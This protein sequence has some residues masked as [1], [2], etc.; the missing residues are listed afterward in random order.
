MAESI[1]AF[2]KRDGD[3][4]LFNGDG[5]FIFYVP[6]MYFTRNCAVTIGDM[7]NIIGILDYTIV[8]KNGKNNG[9]HLFRFPTVFLT[10]P[11][12]IEKLKEV[13]L[14]KYT[15]STDYRLLKYKKGDEI[16][17]SVKVPQ[18]VDNTEQFYQMFTSGKLPTTIPYDKLHEYFPENMRLNGGDYGLNLQL[19]GIM[20]SE[21]CRD[22]K[23]VSRLFR[24]TDMKDMT[25][26]SPISIKDSPNQ[27]SPIAAVTSE[28]WNDSMIHAIMNKD[29]SYSPMESLFVD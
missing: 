7:I 12:E 11:G 5:E 18:I 22:P 14:T 19:F 26:Y 16:V 27:I 1:P 25:A 4:L 20:V 23:D 8:D 10:R 6:E 28:N 2:L 21:L 3:K 17:V 29:A 15:E 9:L 13:K 24:H